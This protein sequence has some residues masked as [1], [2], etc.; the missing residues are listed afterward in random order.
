MDQL[1]WVFVAACGFS[2]VEASGDHS[3]VAVRGLLIQ[4]LLLLQSTGSSMHGL[5]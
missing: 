4:G 2:L 3:L 1:C 5:Q